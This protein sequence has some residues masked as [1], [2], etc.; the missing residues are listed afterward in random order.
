MVLNVTTAVALVGSMVFRWIARTS[1]LLAGI[2]LRRSRST[3]H[4]EVSLTELPIS[5]SVVRYFKVEL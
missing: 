4:R 3:N 2:M 1:L 5:C